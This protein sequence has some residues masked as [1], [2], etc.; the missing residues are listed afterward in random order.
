MKIMKD[1]RITHLFFGLCGGLLVYEAFALNN[2][3]QGDTI[4]EIFWKANR[5]PAR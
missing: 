3:T 4:S 5:R 2:Q 1:I